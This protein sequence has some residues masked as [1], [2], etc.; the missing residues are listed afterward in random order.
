LPAALKA[1]DTDAVVQSWFDP[2]FVESFH[3]V[4][5]AELTTLAS[6]APAD[7]CE[8]YRTLY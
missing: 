5:K 8:R 1:F 7:V 4:R 2:L 3:G 6:L